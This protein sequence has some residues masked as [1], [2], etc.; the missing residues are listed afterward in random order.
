MATTA[1]RS[2]ATRTWRERTGLK[3]V[4]AY[5]HADTVEQL[6]RLVKERGATGRAAVL[7][8][9]IEQAVQPARKVAP[10]SALKTIDREPDAERCECATSNGGRCRNHTTSVIKAVVDGQIAEYGSCKR[11]VRYFKPYGK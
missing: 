3:L 9:L 7:V 5:L 1:A 11:H 10:A 4:Q 8:T 2:R 6:D